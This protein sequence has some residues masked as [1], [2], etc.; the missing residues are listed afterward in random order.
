ML[1]VNL[2]LYRLKRDIK[3]KKTRIKQRENYYHEQVLCKIVVH[4]SGLMVVTP[5]FSEEEPEDNEKNTIFSTK[6]GLQMRETKG[7]HK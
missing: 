6:E 5:G 1:A 2:N 7:N 3:R 4:E